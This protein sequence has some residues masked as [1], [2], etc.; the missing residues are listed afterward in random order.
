MADVG[1][2]ESAGGVVSRRQEEGISPERLALRGRGIDEGSLEH[3][4]QP[5]DE[6]LGRVTT[7]IDDTLP[8]QQSVAGRIADGFTGI[9]RW[10]D[11]V[12]HP[13][14]HSF[15]DLGGETAQFVA[16][17]AATGAGATGT[18]T[19]AALGG[20]LGGPVGLIAGVVVG[21]GATYLGSQLAGSVVRTGLQF[22]NRLVGKDSTTGDG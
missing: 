11:V 19:L 6:L 17:V 15:A 1:G 16:R 12:R 22:L 4:G 2:V 13:E 10:L 8:E 18:V 3:G 5:F 7:A 9:Y 21:L 14:E 20:T